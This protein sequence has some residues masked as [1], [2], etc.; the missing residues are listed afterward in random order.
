MVA[1]ILFSLVPAL[2]F[3]KPDLAPALKQQINTGTGRQS[4]L[5]R[6]FVGL[7]IGLSV[8]L[9]FGAG[10]F[11][12]TMNNLKHV[13]TGMRTERLL[14]FTIDPT[15]AGYDPKQLP[16][17]LNRLHGT[18]T[19]IAG[20]SSVAAT[21]DPE[22]A[23]D[24][25]RTN[26]TVAGFTATENDDMQVERP[27]VTSGYFGTMGMPL[28]AGRTFTDADDR[29]DGP[30][31][32]VVNEKFAKRWL[33]DAHRAVGAHFGRGGGFDTKTDIEIIGVVKDT[34]HA[35]VRDDVVPTAYSPINQ[36]EYTALTFY[37]QTPASPEAM[38]TT[39]RGTI[40][41]LDS[42]LVLD[43]FRTMQQ[44]IE[45]SLSTETMIMLLAT[46][47]GGLAVLLSAVG[48]YGVLAYSAAQRT[49]E[50]GIRM[51]LGADRGSVL[52]M[53]LRE[54]GNLVL[55]SLVI[56]VP[57][58][59]LS[60]KVLRSQLFGV[61]NHDPYT[62]VAVVAVIGLVSLVASMIPARRAAAIDPIKALRYE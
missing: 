23:T 59:L 35:S 29:K 32:A 20:V 28:L 56:A 50:I 10:L 37:L 3:W 49:R 46:S 11:V 26:I 5:R 27:G 42:K 61:S 53:M 17:L 30:K 34:K 43:S 15:L 18:L 31:V 39:V 1:G 57:A 62:L 33:G 22:L 44:Q 8:L 47:F 13:D 45:N 40:Q 16:A 51:A 38:M 9:L 58:A 12:R 21:N 14:T 6:A 2:Q 19:S 55:V 36:L 54:M 24:S 48:L 25:E 41:Q 60:G 4:Q 52:R 7:Q